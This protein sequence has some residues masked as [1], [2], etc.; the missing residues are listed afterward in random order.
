MNARKPWRL[1]AR[2][3][4]ALAIVAGALVWPASDGMGAAV[5]ANAAAGP[6]AVLQAPP[7]LPGPEAA[8]SLA[9]A[10]PATAAA[11]GVADAAPEP[12]LLYVLALM[13]AGLL[14]GY[15]RARL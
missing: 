1:P 12:N 3:L 4:A 7:D 9:A 5:S 14:G 11:S 10:P 6:A 2:F 13:V 15:R 8:Q